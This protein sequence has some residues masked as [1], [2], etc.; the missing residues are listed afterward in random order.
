MSH[1]KM[2]KQTKREVISDLCGRSVLT[3][4]ANKFKIL[5]TGYEPL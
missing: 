5:W 4:S 3:G 2:P 1:P